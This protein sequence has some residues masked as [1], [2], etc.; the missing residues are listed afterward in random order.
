MSFLQF[1]RILWARRALIMLGTLGAFVAAL[2]VVAIVPPSYQANTNLFLDLL[3]PDPV[4]G[5]SVGQSAPEYVKT[6][7]Q[8]IKDYRVAGRAV[9]VL[10]W[11]NSPESAAN[12]AKRP[13]NDNRDFRRW[14][15]QPVIDRTE[16]EWTGNSNILT[17]KYSAS[18]PE[19][20]AKMA[21]TVSQAY[22][23]Q[24]LATKRSDA[25]QN[26]IWFEKQA[27]DLSGQLK[28]LV[29]E[30]TAFEKAN[31]IILQEDASDP[32]MTKLRALSQVPPPVRATAPSSMQVAQL[33]A[34]LASQAKVL[35]P[36]HPDL[37]V[38]RSQLAAAQAQEASEL[39][40]LR[41]GSAPGA[42]STS[43]MLS[44][45][46]QKILAQSG[47]VNEAQRMASEIQALRAQYDKVLAKVADFQQQAKTTESGIRLMAS[48][49]APNKPEF[50]NKPLIL[51]GSLF[52]GLAL[53][54][55]IALIIEL[56][57]RRVRGAEDLADSGLTV[58]GIMGHTDDG[59]QQGLIPRILGLRASRQGRV[60]K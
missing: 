39:A 20:A 13:S 51:I 7:M 40:T 23:D 44:A 42:P 9:D 24:T 15:A 22:I 58:V 8:I 45:Q 35:G 14:L 29:E 59:V 10:G 37:Q 53:G 50:P 27:K 25:Q 54:A 32:E 17:I 52:L 26:A 60:A 4:T 30:K 49:V 6:Q 43:S 31:G 38:L 11:A 1:F 5:L 3:K 28:K 48:A 46:T 12:Y 18:D 33:Q 2:L 57:N 55:M 56:L 41:T 34:Q 36:N 16:V 21:D 47:K 19:V